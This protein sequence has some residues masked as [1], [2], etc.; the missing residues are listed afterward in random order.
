[1]RKSRKSNLIKGAVCLLLVLN[2]IYLVLM[3]LVNTIPYSVV[4]PHAEEALEVLD[5][6]G[7]YP[8]YFYGSPGATVNNFTDTAMIKYMKP[9]SGSI[10][11][12]AMVEYYPRYWYGH[13][14]VW[15]SLLAVF[16]IYQVRYITM[17]V[18]FGCL[19]FMLIEVKE[20]LGAL[21]AAIT[22]LSLCAS[23]FI[24][25]SQALS[26][27]FG[28]VIMFTACGVIL[29]KGTEWEENRRYLFCLLVGS[30]ENFLVGLGRPLLTFGLM[31]MFYLLLRIKEGKTA[32]LPNI[33]EMG[34]TGVFWWSGYAFTW[35][36]KWVLATVILQ[37]NIF[38]SAVSQA[39]YRIAGD[40]QAHVDYF[41]MYKLNVWV[42]FKPMLLLVIAVGIIWL[43]LFLF[44]GRR[45]QLE[46]MIPV[47]LL[48]AAPYVWYFIMANHSEVHYWNAYRLQMLTL[49]SAL[50]FGVYSIDWNKIKRKRK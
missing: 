50:L 26:T 4:Q 17:F 46:Y 43:L 47:L 18:F 9:M 40:S 23:Y 2:V 42:M 49:M 8:I 45:K 34:K 19:F 1:M 35:M 16:N 41:H 27:I 3:I 11:K 5:K 22:L 6:E 29:K 33:F 25:L 21:T 30:V 12:T 20:K 10:L 37:K 38:L 24:A 13:Q 48:G 31:L 36:I 39:E 14:S 15:K 28:A 32:V 44:Y 7:L